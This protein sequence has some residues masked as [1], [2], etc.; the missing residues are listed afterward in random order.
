MKLDWPSTDS[1]SAFCTCAQL[2]MQKSWLGQGAL[3]KQRAP[4]RVADPCHGTLLPR[5]GTQDVK[6]ANQP[7]IRSRESVL[8]DLGY[9][10][11]LNDSTFNYNPSPALV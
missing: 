4:H 5:T 11:L 10:A 1:C 2:Q 8:N 9:L 6:V 3:S 7:T